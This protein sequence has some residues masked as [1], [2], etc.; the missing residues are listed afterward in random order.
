MKHETRLILSIFDSILRIRFTISFESEWKDQP[1]F[2]IDDSCDSIVF[3][4]STYFGERLLVESGY[5]N[6]CQGFL[7]VAFLMVWKHCLIRCVLADQYQLNRL[8]ID[9]TGQWETSERNGR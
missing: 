3:L 7:R 2:M 4:I 5:Q 9:E 6:A 8:P 1:R